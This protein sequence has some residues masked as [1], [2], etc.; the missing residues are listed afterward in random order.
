M[1]RKL[2]DC[3]A[4]VLAH[5]VRDDRRQP[6]MELLSLLNVSHNTTRSYLLD[7]GYKNCIA[8][9]KPYLGE[10]HKLDRLKFARAH[11]SWN[12]EDWCNVIWLEESSFEIGKNSRQSKV[13]QRSYKRYAWDCIKLQL[14]GVHVLCD[15][16]G[17]I[18]WL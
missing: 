6:L 14:L 1:H 12:F 18:Y 2:S 8:P 15:G 4:I 11:E 3:D 16:L 9:N 10:K 5:Y 7:L 17:C 13:W